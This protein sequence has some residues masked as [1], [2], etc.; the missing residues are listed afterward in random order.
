MKFAFAT[1]LF[2]ILSISV[3]H[4]QNTFP[5]SGNVGIGTTSPGNKL[6][7]ADGAD[8]ATPYGTVQVIRAT[9]PSD[10]KFHLSF[11]RS[12]SMYSGIGYFNGTNTLGIWGGG[13]TSMTPTISFT[14]GGSVGI[15]TADPQTYKLAIDPKGAG[16]M[17]V[18]NPTVTGGNY[19]QVVLGISAGTNG[20]PYIQGVTASGSSYGVLA[21]NPNGGNVL[22]GKTSQ[23]VAA[24]IL[25]INGAARANKVVVNTTGADFVFDSS[26]DLKSLDNVENYIQQNKHLPDIESAAEMQKDGVDLGNNQTKLLQKIE[27]LTLYLIEQNKQ[28]KQ[29]NAL[30]ENQK[31]QL[32]DLKREVKQLQA[33]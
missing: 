14:Q 8:D 29:Q 23:A 25:D 9:N 31:Q 15:G 21:I 1:L 27:E 20:Y 30:I 16:G 18:G 32:K 10:N 24:Y 5:A 4:A 13:N 19:T 12:G 11:I 2:I 17:V 3:S 33:K 6:Q 7:I 26:Y 28:L 22:I